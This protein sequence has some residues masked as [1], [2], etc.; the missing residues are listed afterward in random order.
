MGE[1][2]PVVSLPVS[3]LRVAAVNRL[4]AVM[5]AVAVEIGRVLPASLLAV[6]LGDEADAPSWSAWPVRW[7]RP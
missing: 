4:R 2:L 5:D 1:R 3:A 6:A 7:P